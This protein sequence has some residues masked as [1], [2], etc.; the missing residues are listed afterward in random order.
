MSSDFHAQI[1][2]GILRLWKV[3]KGLRRFFIFGYWKDRFS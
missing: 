3:K 1:K 2:A